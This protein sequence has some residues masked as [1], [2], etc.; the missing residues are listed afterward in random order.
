VSST[1]LSDRGSMKRAV[2]RLLGTTAD[3]EAFTEHDAEPEEGVNTALQQGMWKAQ[4]FALAQGQ[5]HRW[6][7]WWTITPE[8]AFE[9]TSDGRV[10]AVCLPEDF[11]RLA[12]D[13]TRSA[14]FHGGQ[15]WGKLITPED[16]ETARGAFY[17]VENRNLNLCCASMPSP[18]LEVRYVHRLAKF[19]GDGDTADAEAELLALAVAYAADALALR[20][21]FR[22]ERDNIA[23]AVARAERDAAQAA[24]ETQQPQRVQTPPVRGS[25]H[26]L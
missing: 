11:L 9:V 20:P 18:A 4:A 19:T 25:H 8:E 3:D 24:R 22:H 1:G 2:Y 21:A 26:F 13:E 12:A 6:K 5:R 23:S 17:F 16:G 7:S 14:V 15:R 10:V